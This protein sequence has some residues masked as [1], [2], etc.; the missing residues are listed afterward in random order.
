M[1]FTPEERKILQ[2]AGRSEYGRSLIALFKRLESK[3]SSIE[4]ITPGNEGAQVEGRKIF[5]EFCNALT[6]GMSINDRVA[7]PKDT[8]DY[9]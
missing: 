4:G 6:K 5:K 9:D 7:K 8:D 2:A 3:M 1:D